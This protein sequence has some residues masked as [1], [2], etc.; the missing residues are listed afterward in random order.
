MEGRSLESEIIKLELFETLKRTLSFFEP[1]N[2]QRMTVTLQ[3]R[4]K[5]S[6]TNG[7]E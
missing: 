6:Y 1:P 3:K 7:I 4:E 2:E 5:E